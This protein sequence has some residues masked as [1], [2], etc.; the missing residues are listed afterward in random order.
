VIILLFG[1][2]GSGKGTQAAFLARRLGIPAISTGEMLRRE[3]QEGTPLGKDVAH[4]LQTGGLVPDD[5]VQQVLAHR[6][7]DPDIRNGLLL[8]GYPRTVEQARFLDALLSRKKLG[9]PCI[10]YLDVPLDILVSRIMSRRQC[11]DCGSIY[12][13]QQFAAGWD[14]TCS[15]DGKPLTR[16]SD[17]RPDV[18][19]QRMKAYESQTAPIIEHYSAGDFHR[20]DA[21]KSPD[22]VSAAIADVFEGEIVY[23]KQF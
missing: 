13:T 23:T 16:R 1:P 4:I 3:C 15:N 9:I 5:A 14:E 10:V 7:E 6:F 2:P 19:A 12:S 21:G 22:E 20:I 18:I 11:P 8:D 17:D